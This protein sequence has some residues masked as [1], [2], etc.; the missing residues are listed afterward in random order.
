MAPL[1][2]KAGEEDPCS[3]WIKAWPIR[4]V[5]PKTAMLFMPA[6]L[7]DRAREELPDALEEGLLARL[8]AAALQRGLEFLQQLLLLRV[9]ADGSLYHHPAE[10]IAGGAAAHRP[11]AFLA[12]AKYPP[13]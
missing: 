7:I 1:R 4:P 3:A 8:M 2:A 11:N 12:N 6:T 10:E 13:G 5:M 9:Q